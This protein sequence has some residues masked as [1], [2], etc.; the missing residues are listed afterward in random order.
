[1]KKL[2]DV[3]T[4]SNLISAALAFIS[5]APLY[6]A[7]PFAAAA[8]ISGDGN[9][10]VLLGC[11]LGC[12]ALSRTPIGILTLLTAYFGLKWIKM[13]FGTP[14]VLQK[15]LLAAAVSLLA[16]AEGFVL[17]SD[18]SGVILYA[19]CNIAATPISTFLA[20]R[21]H[22]SA[23]ERI[24][25]AAR[26]LCMFVIS[27]FSGIIKIDSVPLTLAVG[28]LLTLLF[29]H[30]SGF[31]HGGAAGFVCGLAAGAPYAG[32][33]SVMGMTY[34]M[35][36]A[37]SAFLAATLSW[38]LGLSA[39]GYLASFEGLTAAAIMLSLGTLL[40]LTVRRRAEAPKTKSE[41]EIK[42]ENA[43]TLKRF[44]AAF[45]SLSGVFYTIDSGPR[46][47]DREQLYRGISEAV[48]GCCHGCNDCGSD[49]KDISDSLC[50]CIYGG[51]DASEAALPTAVRV[52]CP[53]PASLIS[54]ANGVKKSFD[55]VSQAG[56]SRL[57]E[58]YR[59]MASLLDSAA[60]R[61]E[62][63]AVR[64]SEGEKE[65]D[66]A[67]DEL[68][69]C[70][71][72]ISLRGK[73]LKKLEIFG[74]DPNM[75]R[76]TSVQIRRRMGEALRQNLSEPV[77]RMHGDTNIMELTTLPKLHTETAKYTRAKQNETVSGDTVSMFETPDMRFC[78]LIS[79]GM[80]S[81]EDASMS[82]RL[83]SLVLEKL[84]KLGVETAPALSAL[85]GALS[86][87]RCEVF[88]TVDLLDADLV[89]ATATLTKA[90]AA[91]TYFLRDGVCRTLTSATPPMGIM[92]EV[93]SESITLSLQKGDCILLVSDGALPEGGGSYI[94]D[95]L[96][97]LKNP[98]AAS[99][100]SR[101]SQC[102]E[103]VAGSGDDLSVC[104]V[105]FY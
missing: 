97:G 40:F 91:P 50:S 37:D 38:M 12:A 73:R 7:H 100:V 19:L 41:R 52:Y 18:A 39:Y 84:L 60:V 92:K 70:R 85:N 54:A 28:C 94:S 82:S 81:G 69:V 78:C 80:G 62:T 5:A 96:T 102:A 42:T 49:A 11:I 89:T 56:L 90:G 68:S 95:I 4:K 35:L 20:A 83:S 57:S 36:H 74:V 77:F 27:C 101:V 6:Q 58:E 23:D 99:I 104:A 75:I 51:A 2:K 9:L 10:F 14:T 8:V 66:R 53:R 86:E 71:S 88:S 103:T 1:M 33:L 16:S 46:T 15:T 98:T 22:R 29:A 55:G 67:L 30:R 31:L 45:S 17:H 34:G 21:A 72:G 13:Q 32:A 87:K 48:E 64:D 3:F 59:D 79:D 24:K 44:A 105:R 93:Y 47:L 25:K 76:A 43:V 26:Y 61:E 65:V 63:Y